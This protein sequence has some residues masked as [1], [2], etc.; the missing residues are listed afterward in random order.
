MQNIPYF[1]ISIIGMDFIHDS[2]SFNLIFMRSVI[3]KN[4]S[5]SDIKYHMTLEYNIFS[6]VEINERGEP[7]ASY[8]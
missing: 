5:T 3:G 7:A 8:K 1:I 6:V 4:L 2:R